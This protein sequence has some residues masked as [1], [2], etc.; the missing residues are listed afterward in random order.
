MTSL[1]PNIRSSE[2]QEPQGWLLLD[3]HPHFSANICKQTQKDALL[4]TLVNNETE[5]ESS[6]MLFEQQ[7]NLSPG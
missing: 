4:D 6:S 5:R 3:I 2:L 1:A 7:M